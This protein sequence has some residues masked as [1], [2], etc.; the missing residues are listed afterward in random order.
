MT[1]SQADAITGILTEGLHL[2]VPGPDADLIATGVLDSLGL[3]E[4]LVQI[5]NRYGLRVDMEALDVEDFRSVTR[6][7]AYVERARAAA[8]T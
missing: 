7:A 5:E 1:G 2:H 3:L 4:L 6:I 8:R